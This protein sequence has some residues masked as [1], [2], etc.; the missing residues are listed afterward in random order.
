M[1]VTIHLEIVLK[2]TPFLNFVL[3][4]YGNHLR[5]DYSSQVIRLQTFYFRHPL[6]IHFLKHIYIMNFDIH[7]EIY[8]VM[9][10]DSG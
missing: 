5:L 4:N 1:L 7:F 2:P 9:Q 8:W 10:N 3:H 6:I